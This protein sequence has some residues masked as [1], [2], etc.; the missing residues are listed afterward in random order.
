MAVEG[1]A[2]PMLS[3]RDVRVRF[4]G[5][6][7][8]D[9]VSFDVKEARD[10]RPDRAER[11]RQDD[12]LQLHQ[13]PLPRSRGRHPLRGTLASLGA[14]ARGRGPR[15][16]ANVPERGALRHAERHRQRDP[17]RA[18]ALAPP[19]LR[20]ACCASPRAC[21]RSASSRDEAAELIAELGL[22][23]GGRP[24]RGRSARSARASGSSSLARWRPSR[25]SSCSTSRSRASI[26]P[27]STS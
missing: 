18:L 20:R 16:R 9:G 7:A 26:T 11:R 4:G 8:L 27:R 22:E 5:V 3:C 12:A 15:H 10:R 19:L 21:E 17:R 1:G 6:T 24:A 25:G 14:A 2:R 23:S 13:P